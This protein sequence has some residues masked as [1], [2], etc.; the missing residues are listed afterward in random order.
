MS[1]SSR[2]R[3]NI[4]PN[5]YQRAIL[6]WIRTGRGHAFVE[7]VAGSGKS[8]TLVMAAH[9]LHGEGLF[10]A[11]NKSIAEELGTRLEDTPMSAS[12]IHSLGYRA[13]RGRYRRTRVVGSKYR[14]I[15]SDLRD[16]PPRPLSH[17]EERVVREHGWP[18]LTKLLDLVR[19]SLGHDVEG[20]INHHAL[21]IR[22]ELYDLA[23]DVVRE[24]MRIGLEMAPA[25]VDFADML[26]L[27]NVLGLSVD[28]YPWVFVD[29]A[30]DLSPAQLGVVIKAV[31]P[32][33]RVLAVGDRRQAIYG[34]AG[35]DCDSVSRIIDRLDAK[36]LPLS[37]CYRCPTSHLDLA[38]QFCSQ[39]EARPGAPVGDVLTWGRA[40]LTGKVREGDL[41]LCRMTAPLLKGAYECIGDGISAA[42]KGR[43]IGEGLI[44]LAKQV[45]RAVSDLEPITDFTERVEAWRNEEI[46]ALLKAGKAEDDDSRM[47]QVHDRADC[48]DVIYRASKPDTLGDLTRAI[49][50]L[51][52]TDRPAVL[53]SSIHRAKGLENDRVIILE[54]DLLRHP[55]ARRPWQMEQER[56]LHYVAL[57][58]AKSTLVFVES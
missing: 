9:A 37:V 46:A 39:I 7:A 26:W 17:E 35:A 28:Q 45:S 50:S 8:S 31:A 51:F 13:V 49:E 3:L 29:E 56:N 23:A 48:L 15:L 4:E 20:V 21:E 25:E 19:V 1:P 2:Q 57:T 5:S 40:E 41:V 42:V 6:D 24:A 47:E 54:P 12:T 33:G 30:Q 34:F 27:P 58:R 43:D 11:F 22:P 38:R 10:L 16:L 14:K 18:T 52:A 53:F 32:G 36:T 55:R 44:K